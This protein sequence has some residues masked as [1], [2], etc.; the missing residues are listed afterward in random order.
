MTRTYQFTLR[1]DAPQVRLD[2]RQWE[3]TYVGTPREIAEDIEE[4]LCR[5]GTSRSQLI[6][7]PVNGNGDVIPTDSPGGSRR[8]VGWIAAKV[9]TEIQS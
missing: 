6:I 7:R 1:D 8:F 2:S 9:W 4:D 5:Y 3:S